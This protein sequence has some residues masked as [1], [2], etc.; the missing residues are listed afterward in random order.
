V[1][2]H[3][4]LAD[5]PPSLAPAGELS[6]TGLLEYFAAEEPVS[7]RRAL[8]EHATRLLA[9][10]RASSRRAA[11]WGAVPAVLVPAVVVRTETAE[12]L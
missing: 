6:L 11:G 2:T 9:W 1:T 8:R 12:V 5:R 4:A 10:L 3:A 7:A